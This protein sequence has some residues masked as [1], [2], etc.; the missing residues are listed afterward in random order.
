MPDIVRRGFVPTDEIEF[1]EKNIRILKTAQQDICTLI[2]RGYS[3]D[4]TTEF[5]GNHFMLSARQ[6]LALK[7]AIAPNND[8]INRQNHLITKLPEKST[9]NIDGLNL[10]ITLEVVLS[11]STVIKCMDNTIRDLAGLRGTYKIVDKTLIAL[12]L[13][14]NKFSDM[15]IDKAVF[16]LDSP[17]SNTGRLKTNIMEM[18]KDWNFKV[19]VNLVYNADVILEKLDNVIT[20]D[21]IILNKCKGWLNTAY[22]IA[23]ENID[24]F[25]YID[26]SEI[27]N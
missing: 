9:V 23:S 25:N 22:E 15:N 27:I 17:V 26:L 13:I 5:V 16:Y 18:S 3:I 12:E 24:H 11:N 4:K 10:I 7:R 6:R 8:I 14:A 2:N 20:T 1:N 19:E 21:G